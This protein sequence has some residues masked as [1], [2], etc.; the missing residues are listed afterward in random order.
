ML[1]LL[2][3]ICIFSSDTESISVNS[4]CRFLQIEAEIFTGSKSEHCEFCDKAKQEDKSCPQ[5]NTI[6][7]IN[8]E[9]FPK[10][11]SKKFDCSE[12]T[13]VILLMNLK[14]FI[15]ELIFS[16]VSNTEEVQPPFKNMD[17]PAHSKIAN[18]LNDI[19]HLYV[20]LIERVKIK[21][22]R[23]DLARYVPLLEDIEKH[24]SFADISDSLCSTII[25][26]KNKYILILEAPGLFELIAWKFKQIGDKINM[27]PEIRFIFIRTFIKLH[28]GEDSYIYYRLLD[29]LSLV[30]TIQKINLGLKDVQSNILYTNTVKLLET[31]IVDCIG[32][33]DSHVQNLI[34]NIL[35]KLE[36]CFKGKGE[37]AFAHKILFRS[38]LFFFAK[39]TTFLSRY[40]KHLSNFTIKQDSSSIEPD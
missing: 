29:L 26:L 13:Y 18:I 4:I 15:I 19:N 27:F 8:S 5:I 34:K 38:Y 3:V 17:E 14:K 33:E 40:E 11:T 28:Q 16:L 22:T 10:I 37:E 9:I 30:C 21:K 32:S 1:L 24:V 31:C 25:D 6:R 7:G 23:H 35:W 20:Y 12:V 39:N 36:N 2:F